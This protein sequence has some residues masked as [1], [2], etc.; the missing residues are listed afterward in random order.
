MQFCGTLLS[1][2]HPY[3]PPCLGALQQTLLPPM[4][5]CRPDTGGSKSI[6]IAQPPYALA[7]LQAWVYSSPKDSYKATFPTTHPVI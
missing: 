7:H 6:M 3:T 1:I 5:A 2:L 4:L